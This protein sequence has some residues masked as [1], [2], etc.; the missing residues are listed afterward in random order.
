MTT[1]RRERHAN[2]G[3]SLKT[4]D[5]FAGCGGLSEGLAQAGAAESRWAI[6]YEFPAAEAFK[7]NHPKVRHIGL[8]PV[9][10]QHYAAIKA[11]ARGSTNQS[12][13][14]ACHPNSSF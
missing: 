14:L 3:I 10:C 4:L 1:H 12:Q 5:I 13:W 8:C 9:G 7:L 6:E 2:D 11:A